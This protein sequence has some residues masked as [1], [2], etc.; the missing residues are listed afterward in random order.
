MTDISQCPINVQQQ[1]LPPVLVASASPQNNSGGQIPYFHSL[2]CQWPYGLPL[3]S[4]WVLY[5]T[6]NNASYLT[7]QLQK[8][9]DL[10]IKG[11]SSNGNSW[12]ISEGLN[13]VTDQQVST[14]IGCAFAT[15]Y[16]AP[17]ETMDIG[18]AGI[19]ENNRGFMRGPIGGGRN[20]L[21][22][23]QIEF[24][25]TNSSIVENF[26]RPWSILA[27]HKG[28][29]AYENSIKATINVLEYRLNGWDRDPVVRKRW[30]YF[31]CVPFDVASYDGARVDQTVAEER[32]C[33]FCFNGYTVSDGSDT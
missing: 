18:W 22:A 27:M 15:K 21:A 31:E 13:L 2:L 23:F 26:I 24:N 25:E 33:S 17:G 11:S 8:I 7:E 20:N 3:T 5:I 6:P 12:Q 16:Y 14:V 10:E 30:T 19:Q 28:L 32:K 29:F 1:E 9:G 4:F